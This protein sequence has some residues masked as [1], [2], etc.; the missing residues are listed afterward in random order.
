MSL[1]VYLQEA[2]QVL[3]RCQFLIETGLSS[4][5]VYKVDCTA[6]LE[7]NAFY[8]SSFQQFAT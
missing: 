6:S 1:D 2:N 4:P 7:C 8:G 5:Q 3:I